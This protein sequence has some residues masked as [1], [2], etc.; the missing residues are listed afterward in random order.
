MI[1]A[2]EIVTAAATEY[3]LVPEDLLTRRRPSR[4]ASR[5]RGL[6]WWLA[7]RLTP[8][9]WPEIGE[10]LFDVNHSSAIY[11]ARGAHERM[12]DD[13]AFAERAEAIALVLTDGAEPAADRL[14]AAAVGIDALLR[15]IAAMRADIAALRADLDEQR[16]R[17]V[18]IE[19]A[20]ASARNDARDSAMIAAHRK[21]AALERR[22]LRREA[23]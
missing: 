9:S 3:G 11:G 4:S 23:S 8:W 14:D 5:A 15:D 12:A 17:I 21:R 6:A 18:K 13:P 2:R 22:R 1:T 7:R 16:A 19:L 20:P 10:R